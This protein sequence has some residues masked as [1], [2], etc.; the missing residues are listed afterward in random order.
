M[1]L[2]LIL[3]LVA[4]LVS[5]LVACGRSGPKLGERVIPLGQPVPKGGGRYHV[6]EPYQISGVWYRPKEEQ[7]YNRVGQASWYGELFHGRYTANGEIYDMDRLSAAHPTLPLPIYAQVTNLSNG[8]TIIVR[9]N[10]RGPFANDRIIDLSRRSAEVLGFRRNGTAVV[11]VKYLGRAPLSGDDSYERRYLASRGLQQYAWKT[12]SSSGTQDPIVTASIPG[13]TASAPVA[14]PPPVR[15]DFAAV[16]A[17]PPP[18][19][20]SIGGET[21]LLASPES[22]G[23]IAPLAAK[24]QTAPPPGGPVI[25]AGSFKVKDNADRARTALEPVA[26]V[27]V[28]EIEVGGEVFYRVRVGPFSTRAEAALALPRVTGAGYRGAKIVMQN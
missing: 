15:R 24:P 27:D 26:P 16:S 25:Q 10:D 14:P 6:G 12:K 23:A 9:V 2:A 7:N 18:K 11:R 8:R 4:N 1:R 22:T 28:T 3:I 21:P 20:D 13:G 5:G 19:S 17:A